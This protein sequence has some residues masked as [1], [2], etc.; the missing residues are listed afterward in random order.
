ML[1][2]IRIFVFVLC[3]SIALIIPFASVHPNLLAQTN[4]LCFE[5]G[6]CIS[7]RIREYWQYNG[8]LPVFGMPI[9]PLQVETIEGQ[10]V[11]VQWFERNR[12][13]VHPENM[14]PYDILPGRL[15][16]ELLAQQGRSWQ[17]FPKGIP[18]QNCKFFAETSHSV[19]GN[20]LALWRSNGLELDGQSGTSEA[21]SL[22]LFGLPLS[23][24]QTETLSDGRQYAVQWF[25]RARLE[26]HPENQPP[27]DVL[28]GLLG[29]EI[30]TTSSRNEFTMPNLVGKSQDE[31]V[32]TLRS[33][34]VEPT[35]DYQTGQCSS[36]TVV[37]TTPK[38][39]ERVSVSS[40]V[41]LGVCS[42]LI[43]P[44]LIGMDKN[45]ALATLR[46]MGIE[47]EIEKTP[48]SRYPENQVWTTEPAPNTFIAENQ[49]V[50]LYVWVHR[51]SGSGGGGSGGGGGGDDDSGGGGGDDDS[52]GGGDD[53]DSGGGGDDDD[54]GGGGGGYPSP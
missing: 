9:T 8:G 24:L 50:V 47:P 14:S 21:E 28:S 33:M 44:N 41:A 20:I 43:M 17:N 40:G 35:I 2:H 5:T 42:P 30:H 53:D 4:Q 29:N 32:N 27:Y 11:Q 12:L 54:S 45:E 48:D 31:A 3:V 46:S 51:D 25:E 16:V 19:C 34:Q 13:E 7:G 39:G 15:G 36:Y 26:L 38:A 10:Q 52:G 18:Q 22:A 1:Q 37:S 6:F 49:T 23:E